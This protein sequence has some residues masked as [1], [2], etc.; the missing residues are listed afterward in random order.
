MQ[1]IAVFASGSGSNAENLIKYFS[2]HPQIE[3]AKVCSNRADAY[4]HQRADKLGIPSET[5]SR[6]DFKSEQFAASLK[7]EG[8]TCLILAGFLWLIPPPLIAT[9]QKRI[10][11]IHPSLL[12]DFGG[13]GM[14]GSRVHEA[15]ISSGVKTSGITI[16]L[17]NEK[18]DEGKILFQ[19]KTN[20]SATDDA[21][22]LA[23]RIHH[24][25]HQ[26][27]PRVIEKYLLSDG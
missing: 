4:V 26:H 20:I 11:N 24:L 5:F 2:G 10:I 7:E 13:K 23:G 27:F 16:H 25:E 21:E 6:I 3:I 1:K 18:Y 19:A 14:Y 15:V 22:S 12:P 17:V 9:F 8:I